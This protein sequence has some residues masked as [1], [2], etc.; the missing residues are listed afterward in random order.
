MCFLRA[1]RA[2]S[3]ALEA[4]GSESCGEE[5]AAQQSASLFT[6][7][8]RPPIRSAS[9]VRSARVCA[10][11][12]HSCAQIKGLLSVKMAS[13]SVIGKAILPSFIRGPLEILSEQLDLCVPG[14]GLD[15]R[16]F[17]SALVV[18]SPNQTEGSEVAVTVAPMPPPAQKAGGPQIIVI[19]GGV[20]ILPAFAKQP[21]SAVARPVLNVSVTIDCGVANVATCRMFAERLQAMM[22]EPERMETIVKEKRS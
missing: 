15:G 14:L 10:L 7:S 6:L 22:K 11:C 21:G 12:S 8:V 1:S 5:D 18:T 4:T 13:A 3:A 17:G 19:V 9:F 2:R 20:Q 16:N